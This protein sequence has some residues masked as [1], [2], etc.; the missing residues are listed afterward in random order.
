VDSTDI[1]KWKFRVAEADRYWVVLDYSFHSDNRPAEGV[2]TVAG[3]Q[4]FFPTL[5]TGDK[6]QHFREHRIGM[7][8]IPKEGA[9]ELSLKPIATPS[10]FVNVRGVTLIPYR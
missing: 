3:Q 5:P 2:I 1:V 7:V 10:G 8:Q 4:L 6:V 9:Y